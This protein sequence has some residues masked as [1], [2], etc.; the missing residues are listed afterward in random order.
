MKG[1]RLAWQTCAS[2]LAMPDRSSYSSYL[3]LEAASYVVS[4]SRQKQRAVLDL[5]DLIAKQPFLVGDYQTTDSVGHT[6]ENLLLDRYLFSYW[7]DHAT[8]E[9]RISDVVRV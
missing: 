7:V 3:S 4:L 9:V 2:S 1:R 5:A 6:V 8:R